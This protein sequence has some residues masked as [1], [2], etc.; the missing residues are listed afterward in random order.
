MLP[1][2]IPAAKVRAPTWDAVA[3]LRQSRARSINDRDA[4]SQEQRL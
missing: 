2:E 1:V 3:S 4:R